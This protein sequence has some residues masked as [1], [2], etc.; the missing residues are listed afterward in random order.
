MQRKFGRPFNCK[1]LLVS[2]PPVGGCGSTLGWC[3]PDSLLKTV[4]FCPVLAK[5]EGGEAAIGSYIALPP[6]WT[7]RA[8]ICGPELEVRERGAY[9]FECQQQFPGP[10]R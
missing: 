9:S 2:P 8:G 3:L 1:R 5:A 4:A 10:M 7:P 6:G